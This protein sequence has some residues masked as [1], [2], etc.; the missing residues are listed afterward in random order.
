MTQQKKQ[1][2]A[3]LSAALVIASAPAIS[4][5]IPAITGTFPHITTTF[6]NLFTT[7][8]ALF[9]IFGVF[10]SNLMEKRLGQKKNILLG[11]AIVAIFGT[12]PA[13]YDRSFSVLFL[14]RCILGLGIGL[15]NR[16]I[17]QNISGLYQASIVKKARALGLES[18]FEGLGGIAMTLGVGQLVR[19]SWQLSFIVYGIAVIGFVLILL[20][21]PEKKEALKQKT[22][23]T[24]IL[25]PQIKGKMLQLAVLLFLI[26]ALFIIFN[27][28]ITP[29][30]LEKGIGDATEGSNMIAA[31]SIGAF[32]AGNLFG[33]TYG[34][35]KNYILPAAAFLAG[36]FI[37]LAT[38]S[39]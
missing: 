21:L 3:L 23:D 24:K 36:C 7:I 2:I 8:P 39:T 16:L 6:I 12:M 19:F 4:A 20:F 17:I 30:L 14:S 11:L 5:N 26:V 13:W 34:K 33:R 31:I 18:A 1:L 35:L 29:L 32:T 10:L 15:F 27:L 9:I 38:L 37:I 25:A 22:K 28:Q